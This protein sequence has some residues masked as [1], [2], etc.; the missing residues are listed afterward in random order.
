MPASVSSVT[1]VVRSVGSNGDFAFTSIHG[2]TFRLAAVAR[3]VAESR[4]A[5]RN[6]GVRGLVPSS[7]RGRFGNT[8]HSVVERRRPR[9]ASH[10]EREPGRTALV[11]GKQPLGF[12]WHVILE[13]PSGQVFLKAG[14]VELLRDAAAAKAGS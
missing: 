2:L 5:T 9:A 8:G 13:L 3:Y 6:H 14:Q 7:H 10:D 11:P 1:L 4:S 12:V